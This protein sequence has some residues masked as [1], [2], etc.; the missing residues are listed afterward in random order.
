MATHAKG[1]KLTKNTFEPKSSI[2]V[3]TGGG[4]GIGKAIALELAKREASTI[5]LVDIDTKSTVSLVS[6]IQQ[7]YPRTKAM[8]IKANCCQEKDIRYVVNKVEHECGPIDAFFVN[9]GI[10]STGGLDVSEDEWELIWKLNVMQILYVARHLMPRFVERKRGAFV[11]TASAAGLLS[12]PGA[13]PYAVTKHAAVAMAEWLAFTYAKNNIQVACLCPQ[14]VRTDMTAL[15]DG[16]GGPAGLD[17]MIEPADAARD[18]I[19][20]LKAGSFLILPHKQVYKH[21]NRKAKDYDG[22]LK[23]MMKIDSMFGETFKNVPPNSRL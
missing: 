3:I 5:V 10:L 14:A 8:A 9:A 4:N 11:I 12:M 2:C 19:E 1:T 22:F 7:A 20:T 6:Q 15:G 13:L 17:G 21:M 18:T 16:N 23:A